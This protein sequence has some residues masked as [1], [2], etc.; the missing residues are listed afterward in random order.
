MLRPKNY[1]LLLFSHSIMSDSFR[2]HGPQHTRLPCPS[3]YP[4]ACSNSCPSSQW[5]HPTISIEPFSCL[6]SFAAS[7]SFPMNQL[8]PSGSQSIGASAWASVLP[9]NIQSW[10]PIGL[11]GLISLQSK[12]L[13]RVFFS[14]T[15]RKHQFSGTQPSL[16]FN[17]YIHIWLLEKP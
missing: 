5:C 8:F 3:P 10:F 15:V 6:Q 16:W 12:G 4:R 17:P 1:L 2:S 11:T 9:M 14:T 13:S 7:G